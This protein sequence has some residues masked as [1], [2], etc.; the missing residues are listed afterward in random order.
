[1]SAASSSRF[2]GFATSKEPE[3]GEGEAQPAADGE[4]EV[5][6]RSPEEPQLPKSY[7]ADNFTLRVELGPAGELLVTWLGRV[8]ERHP[9]LTLR[10]YFDTLALAAA[11]ASRLL[12]FELEGLNHF[13]SSTIAE[14]V[15][16]FQ[17]L[18]TFGISLRVSFDPEKRWQMITC[19]VF[20][21]FEAQNPR[22]Q[23]VEAEA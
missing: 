20:R 5:S 13:N 22:L 4:A 8:D 6:E 1:V 19:D 11:Q 16:F 12:V 21:R 2:W 9:S 17:R 14:I 18:E 10:P 7:V 23:L 15:R 3:R